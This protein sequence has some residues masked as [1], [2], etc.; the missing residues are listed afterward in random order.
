MKCNNYGHLSLETCRCQTLKDEKALLQ[1]CHCKDIQCLGYLEVG[2]MATQSMTSNVAAAREVWASRL[3]K[4]DT[5]AK[6]ILC[7][8]QLCERLKL[9]KAKPLKATR[10]LDLVPHG[11]CR[12]AFRRALSKLSNSSLGEINA[13]PVLRTLPRSPHIDTTLPPPQKLS[14]TL[15]I[16]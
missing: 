16:S 9:L 14:T 8:I 15:K 7:E 6:N 5:V 4:S 2:A 10:T 12:S 13:A 1:K 11:R 3:S